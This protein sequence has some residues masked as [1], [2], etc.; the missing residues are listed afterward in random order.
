MLIFLYGPDD[1]RRIQKKKDIGAE[2]QKKHSNL[3]LGSF[4]LEVEGSADRLLEFARSQSI[5]ESAKL[6]IAENAF[7]MEA[8]KLAKLLKPLVALQGTTV[9]LSE[10]DKPVKAL[11]FLLE[12]PSLSQKFEILQG[13]E[14]QYFIQEQAKRFGVKLAPA[15]AQFLGTVYAGNSWA[16]VTELQKL[17]AL[18][19]GGKSGNRTIEKSDLDNLDLEVAP[20]YWALLNGMKSIDTHTRLYALEKLFSMSDPAPKLF[21]IL[22]A[23][24]GAKTP[25]M[26]DYDL[27]V[28]SGKLDYEEALLELTLD[29]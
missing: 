7:E 21:N 10:H 26:A 9:L 22:A 28:K 2:F 18:A 19:W 13:T 11:A 20:D 6:A 15:A 25:R 8:G 27:M 5:F 1:F 29:A 16:L 4:D 17:S 12:K 14:L 3:G 24:A 23:Q